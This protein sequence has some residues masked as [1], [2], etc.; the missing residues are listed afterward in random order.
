M[1]AK[2]TL[3]RAE[4]RLSWLI[5]GAIVLGMAVIAALVLWLP[6]AELFPAPVALPE[7][8]PRLKAAAEG[9]DAIQVDA[10]FDPAA[11]TLTATQTMTLTN[12]TGGP[13]SDIVLRSYSGAY[14]NEETSPVATDELYASAYP[15]GFDAGGLTMRGAAVNGSLVLYSLKD[16]QQTVL[17]LPLDDPWQP[18]EQLTVTLT[19]TVLIPRCA[20]RFG[21]QDG[22]YALGNVFPT[23]ALWQDGA[24]REDAYVSIGDPFL[25]ECA[26]WTVR[27]TTPR[28][29]SIAATGWAE[30]AASG[31]VQTF[32][33]SATAVRDFAI[34]LSDSFVTR[35]A[36]EGETMV[37]ACAENDA[38]AAQ[39]LAAAR[40]SLRSYSR[41]WGSYPYPTLTVAAVAFPYS[42]MTYPRLTMLSAA[43][44]AKGGQTLEFSVAHEVAHQWW[45][46]LVGSDGFRQPWQDEALAQYA[47]MD[48]IGDYYGADARA[49]AVFSQ[50][51]TAMRITIPRG[52]TP[53]SPLD[54][55]ASTTEYNQVAMLRGAALF[56]A[57][58]TMMGAP[59]V[60][61]ALFSYADAYG[62]GFATREAL[63]H[64]FEQQAARELDDL[65]IDYLDTN[66]IN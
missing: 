33:M 55:F 35:T 8:A 12:R 47:L 7:D 34:V 61:E 57:L 24:W 37:I 14:L 51:E 66:V 39:M 53:G 3:T 9:L 50:I 45:G 22:V 17:S 46:A 27:L 32:T 58:E 2:Q 42:G 64:C 43:H 21:V 19:Y 26:N 56:V 29:Y 62:F 59:A 40:Q 41:R 1:K 15:D 25:S 49:S 38:Q 48:Y 13:R 23:L 6:T 5:A 4:R 20:S 60:D 11:R 54:Y 31:D 65:F 10:A 63:I 28:G 30:P 16:V 44:A 36:M 52:I 18:D